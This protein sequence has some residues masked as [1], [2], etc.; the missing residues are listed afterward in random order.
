[1]TIKYYFEV[2]L[3]KGDLK[4]NNILKSNSI[5][6][7][8]SKHIDIRI[9][10]AYKEFNKWIKT[11]MNLV[12]VLHV[13]IKED[14]NILSRNKESAIGLFGY[15]NGRNKYPY[16]KLAIGDF[17]D[18][19]FKNG[20]YIAIMSILH[21]YAHELVHFEQWLDNKPSLEKK[22]DKKATKL[23]EDFSDYKK[24]LLISNKKIISIVQ[25]GDKYHN[26]GKF[27]KAIMYYETAIY[28]NC[29]ESSVYRDLGDAY[30]SLERYE[31]AITYYDKAIKIEPADEYSLIGK[32]FSLD[33]LRRYN[34]A[35]LCYDHVIELFPKDIIAYKNKGYSLFCSNKFQE[36]I[37][38]FS[39]AIYLDSKDEDA[40]IFKAQVMER[41]TKYQEAIEVYDSAIQINSKNA[42]LYNGKGN[43]LYLLQ[44]YEE[45]IKYYNKAI[46]ID[47]EYGDVYYNRAISFIALNKVKESMDDLSIAIKINP[48]Y[49]QYAKEEKCFNKISYLM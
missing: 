31:D 9:K 49:K 24:G 16:I 39:K 40:Y 10:L 38:C 30:S 25:K 33:K 12:K 35:I 32:G 19:C 28:F 29:Q 37:E 5:K 20:E 26:L 3:Y 44:K 11:Y 36:A 34:D 8:Y 47:A 45:S 4:M 1:M 48:I 2:C 17:E 41:L 14:Y 18:L 43:V 13:F 42:F 27:Q 22:A 7:H 21:T 23:V 15:P 46:Q 6:M